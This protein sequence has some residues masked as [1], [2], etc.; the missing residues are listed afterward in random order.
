MREEKTD[1]FE[2]RNSLQYFVYNDSE[3]YANRL[4]QI[5]DDIGTKMGQHQPLVAHEG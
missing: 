1:L 4:K 2:I 5:V 3:S